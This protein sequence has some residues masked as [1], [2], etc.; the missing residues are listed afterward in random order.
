MVEKYI[1]QLFL[2]SC[3]FMWCRHRQTLVWP[4]WS[5]ETANQPWHWLERARTLVLRGKSKVDPEPAKTWEAEHYINKS[6]NKK[7]FWQNIWLTESCFF[8]W[9]SSKMSLLLSLVKGILATN[10][11]QTT[12]FLICFKAINFFPA[13][14]EEPFFIFALE[15]L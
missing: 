11:R 7:G 10:P 6:N 14:R 4:Q 15:L 13:L 12:T 1:R 9:W 3:T 2:A 8:S 5:P